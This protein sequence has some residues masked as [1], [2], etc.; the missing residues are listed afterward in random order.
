MFYC[1]L[2]KKS[3]VVVPC[4]TRIIYVINGLYNFISLER[5]HFVFHQGG[6]HEA[7]RVCHMDAERSPDARGGGKT[8][9]DGR[10]GDVGEGGG[11]EGECELDKLH[12]STPGLLATLHDRYQLDDQNELL[13]NY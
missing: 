11:L 2:E 12:V 13:R 6:R 8:P 4:V 9:G 7:G 5:I 10:V 1:L 3:Y